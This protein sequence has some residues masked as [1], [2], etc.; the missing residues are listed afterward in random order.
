MPSRRTFLTIG[1]V[2]V[3]SSAI[4][5]GCGQPKAPESIAQT[6]TTPLQPLDTTTTAPG[7]PATDLILLRTSSSI[8]ALAIDTYGKAAVVGGADH[9]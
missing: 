4:L 5:V 2:G 7:S 9:A 1:G 8:E 6:G 3:V